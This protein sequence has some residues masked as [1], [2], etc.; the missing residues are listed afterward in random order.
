MGSARRSERE[1]TYPSPMPPT[2]PPDQAPAFGLDIARHYSSE[3]QTYRDLWAPVL[4][5]LAHWLLDEFPLGEARRVL[6]LGCGVGALLP[7]PSRRGTD[8]TDRWPG[9]Q[10]GD[11]GPGSPGLPA[12]GRRRGR[13]TVPDGSFDAVVMAFLQPSRN[14]AADTHRGWSPASGMA[15]AADGA[16]AL[17]G[18]LLTNGQ[19][20]TSADAS[21]GEVPS[22]PDGRSQATEQR[23]AARGRMPSQRPRGL[24]TSQY[25]THPLVAGSA[26][27]RLGSAALL[28]SPSR[29]QA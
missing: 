29:S 17:A 13:A 20:A 19:C 2:P 21:H 28:R 27:K 18:R 22:L 6:D 9:S 10:R 23:P 8:G 12:A 4:A 1:A 3:A 24:D 5:G 15:S 11:G 25:V 7:A 16:R 14:Q 26:F